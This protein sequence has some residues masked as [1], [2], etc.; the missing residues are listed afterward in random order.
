[1]KLEYQLTEEDLFNFNG[2]HQKHSPVAIKARRRSIASCSI[3][4][5]IVMTYL[6]TKDH[7]FSPWLLLLSAVLAV[8][9]G[10]LY[11]IYLKSHSRRYVKK[12]IREGKNISLNTPV[13][14]EFYQDKILSNSSLGESKLK[15]DVVERIEETEDY[16]FIYISSLQA[17]IIPKAKVESDIPVSGIFAEIQ[18]LKKQA[19]PAG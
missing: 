7:G 4:M 17:I 19:E 10:F 6:I 12:T 8:F 13:K 11:S 9:V 18:T 1:M 3:S 15:W 14:V 2:F 16:I 5:F